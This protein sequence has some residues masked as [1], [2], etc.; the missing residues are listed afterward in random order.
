M[1]TRGRPPCSWTTPLRALLSCPDLQA[2]FPTCRKKAKHN[3]PYFLPSSCGG[4]T[5][6]EPGEE[7]GWQGSGQVQVPWCGALNFAFRPPSANTF[8][9][10]QL[11]NPLLLSRCSGLVYPHS[12]HLLSSRTSFKAHFK[13]CC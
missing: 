10:G 3:H 1:T 7:C 2:A 6:V 9:L 13:C 5:I 11:H 8:A 12:L 4:K